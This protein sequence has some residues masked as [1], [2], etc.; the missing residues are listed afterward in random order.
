VTAELSSGILRLISINLLA[1][2]QKPP[3]ISLD[4]AYGAGAC[5]PQRLLWLIPLCLQCQSH[6]EVSYRVQ[7]PLIDQ[8]SFNASLR[9]ATCAIV[10]ASAAGPAAKTHNNSARTVSTLECLAHTIGL[11]V[12]DATH[13]S[14]MDSL[15]RQTTC[16]TSS[17]NQW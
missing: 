12:V 4:C 8:R 6:Q 1:V 14:L 10:A 3:R 5:K 11:L 16:L 7:T 9:R 15:R 17:A 2:L 13:P